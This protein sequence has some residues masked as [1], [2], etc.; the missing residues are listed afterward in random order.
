MPK[1]KGTQFDSEFE[2]INGGLLP[3]WESTR[4]TV[5][6][7]ILLNFEFSFLPQGPSWSGWKGAL[8]VFPMGVTPFAF[9]KGVF[10]RRC[11]K[12]QRRHTQY[13]VGRASGPGGPGTLCTK[14]PN[15]CTKDPCGAQKAFAVASGQLPLTR[16]RRRRQG[17]T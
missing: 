11:C 8:L 14:G 13:Y 16:V 10:R 9:I 7:F 12:A 5:Q 4:C 17:P 6:H 3:H 15:G 2:L 1:W